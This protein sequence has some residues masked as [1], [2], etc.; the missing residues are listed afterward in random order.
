M[1]LHLGVIEQTNTRKRER[2]GEREGSLKWLY[3]RHNISL[4]GTGGAV[5]ARS[6]SVS[7]V[8]KYILRPPVDT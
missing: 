3:M 6:S 1:D 7:Y 8:S 2:G 5:Q 4:G